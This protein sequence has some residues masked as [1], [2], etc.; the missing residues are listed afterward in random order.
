MNVQ[1]VS[2]LLS[3]L[4]ILAVAA[5]FL[6]VRSLAH[7]GRDYAP[8]QGNAYRIRAIGFWLLILVDCRS[9]SGCSAKIPTPHRPPRLR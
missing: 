1:T 8:V 3:L 9:A 6:R 4:L 5:V 2:A 7:E